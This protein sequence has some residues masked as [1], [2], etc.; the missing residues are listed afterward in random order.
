MGL[1]GEPAPE[2]T[3]TKIDGTQVPLAS[4]K[5]KVVVMDLGHGVDLASG[6][7]RLSR[8]TYERR[9]QGVVF[10]PV[11]IADRKEKVEQ[12]VNAF[13]G[14]NEGSASVGFR[15]EKRHRVSFQG[16]SHSSHF[17]H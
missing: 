4:L 17:D 16:G 12:Y 5:G 7:A 1:E 6:H 14:S 8:I 10:M 15:R 11:A 3:L 2:V 13:P 9:D